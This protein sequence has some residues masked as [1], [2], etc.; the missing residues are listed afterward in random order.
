MIFALLNT[1]CVLV[2]AFCSYKI[3]VITTK[4]NLLKKLRAD[5]EK[6][7]DDS[8]KINI[9]KKDS[10]KAQLDKV[11][12]CAKLLGKAEYITELRNFL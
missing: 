7:A 8:H 4:M 3:G 2:I 1:F 10:Q 9:T 11:Q 6:S 5:L 12:D